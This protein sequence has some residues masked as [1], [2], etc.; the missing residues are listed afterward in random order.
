[1]LAFQASMF[2]IPKRWMCLGAFGM[3]DGVVGD[4]GSLLST[5]THTH[6][7]HS[8]PHTPLTVN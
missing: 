1:M 8:S 6:T 2:Q 4:D 3:H 5:H 7:P